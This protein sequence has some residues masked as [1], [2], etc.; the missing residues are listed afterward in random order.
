VFT[1]KVWFRVLGRQ[2]TRIFA[3]LS[4][5][6]GV[7]G[8]ARVGSGWGPWHDF[9]ASFFHGSRDSR[10]YGWHDVFNETPRTARA[11]AAALD[12]DW[13]HVILGP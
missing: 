4:E 10:D 7:L 6:I 5:V 12:F 1:A 11:L 13:S 8:I 3:N 9:V 2:G